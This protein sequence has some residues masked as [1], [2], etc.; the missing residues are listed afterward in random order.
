MTNEHF[1][2]DICKF[3]LIS[4]MI[5]LR[6]KNYSDKGRREIQNTHVMFDNLFQKSCHL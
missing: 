6:M 5:L 4:R 3:M 1:I 2:E